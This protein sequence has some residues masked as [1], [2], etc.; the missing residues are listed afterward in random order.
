[1]FFKSKLENSV[2][3]TFSTSPL[4]SHP[5][6]FLPPLD[7]GARSSLSD[8]AA[9]LPVTLRSWLVPL[10]FSFPGGLP[11]LHGLLV[12]GFADGGGTVLR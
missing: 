1:M 3:T 7:L 10:R 4:V 12:L 2:L 8:K 6:P 11:L 5:L 9:V